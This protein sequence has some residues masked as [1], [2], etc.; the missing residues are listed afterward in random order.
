MPDALDLHRVMSPIST[1]EHL[2]PA[3]VADE[4]SFQGSRLLDTDLDPLSINDHT[5]TVRAQARDL[6]PIALTEIL[7]VNGE[8][9]LPASSGSS[10]SRTRIEL[11]LLRTLLSVICFD[12]RFE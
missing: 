6:E 3:S 7:K 10:T 1:R 9:D 12:C 5:I 8:I 2:I 4:V 11:R